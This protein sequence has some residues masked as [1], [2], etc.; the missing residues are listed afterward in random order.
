[1]KKNFLGKNAEK[2]TK[3]R[4]N[5]NEVSKKNVFV[6]VCDRQRFYRRTKGIITATALFRDTIILQ[7][8]LERYI[9]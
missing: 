5:C 7:T 9:L 3:M 6:R 1:M 4:Q 8:S 2:Y